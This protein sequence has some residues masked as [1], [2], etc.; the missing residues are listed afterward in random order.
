MTLGEFIAKLDGVRA[1]PRGILALCP[2][3][4][5]RRQSLSVNEGE[6]G[7]LVKCWAGCTTAEIVAA[8]ELRLCDLFYDAGLPRQSRP[9]PLAHPRRDRNRIAFQLRFHGDK[10]FLRAQAVLDAAKDLDIATWTEG[11]LNQALGAV[12]KAYTDR[13]RADLLDQVAFGL[14]SRALEK[15]SP[16]AA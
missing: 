2:S 11:Q 5:D 4:P 3:H 13:E 9:R 15:G 8:M 12:A 6:R 16:H 14:R 10:L 7:L 1:T